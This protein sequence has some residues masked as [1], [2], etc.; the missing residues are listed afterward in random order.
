MIDM[1]H[2]EYDSKQAQSRPFEEMNIVGFL[3]FFVVLFLPC[4]SS[5]H[6]GCL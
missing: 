3:L 1:K 6:N 5:F 2:S 4:H